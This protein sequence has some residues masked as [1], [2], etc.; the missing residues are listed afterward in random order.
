[1]VAGVWF[2]H[3]EVSQRNDAVS[4]WDDLAEG[5]CRGGRGRGL[6]GHTGGSFSLT[7]YD[8]RRQRFALLCRT[9]YLI[10][11]HLEIS[12]LG[13]RTRNCHVTVLCAISDL[14]IFYIRVVNCID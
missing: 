13:S 2:F 1:M 14:G 6:Q 10:L 4:T 7:L 8:D 3:D 9:V 12:M 11:Q 5:F